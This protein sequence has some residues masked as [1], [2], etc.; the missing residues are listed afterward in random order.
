MYNE[1]K[2]RRTGPYSHNRKLQKML[3]WLEKNIYKKLLCFTIVLK[4]LILIYNFVHQR[5]LRTY[6]VVGIRPICYRMNCTL[7][8]FEG[9]ETG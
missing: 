6:K 3:F 1:V 7:Q 4:L 8:G 5:F 9:V 2:D